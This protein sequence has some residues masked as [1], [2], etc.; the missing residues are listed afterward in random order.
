M[1]IDEPIELLIPNG[2]PVLTAQELLD[3]LSK[4]GESYDLSQILTPVSSLG[5]IRDSSEE[6]R[7]LTMFVMDN[8]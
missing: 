3:E 7:R 4:L 6:Q 1:K 8:K 2:A 5:S